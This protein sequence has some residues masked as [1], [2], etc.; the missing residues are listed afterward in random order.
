MFQR[1]DFI[2]ATSR[3]VD[4]DFD[5]AAQAGWINEDLK[6]QTKG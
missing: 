2:R 4:L 1:L 5:T 6:N 3:I